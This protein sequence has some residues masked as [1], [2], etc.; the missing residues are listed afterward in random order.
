MKLTKETLLA[1]VRERARSV[2][3]KEALE[4]IERAMSAVRKAVGFGE[5]SFVR[6]SWLTDEPVAKLRKK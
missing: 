1:H 5:G 3:T 4:E 6:T 2:G